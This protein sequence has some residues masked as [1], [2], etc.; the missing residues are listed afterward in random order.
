MPRRH[1]VKD[2]SDEEF[3]FVIHRILEGDTDR[4]L[5]A[6]FEA[7]YPDKKLAKSSLHRW[8]EATGNELAERYRLARFQAKQLLANLQEDGADKHQL[9]MQS[10]EDKLLTAT[11]EVISAD[12]LKLLR[13]RQ[14]EKKRE[15]QE[16]TLDLKE[17]TLDFQKEKADR[18]AGLQADKFN[19]A[20]DAWQF[21][22]R[23]FAQR[24]TSVVD[25]LTDSSEELLQDLESHLENQTA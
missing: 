1:V 24:D 23:W 3:E 19:I 5:S 7:Q 17:R 22:L 15:L 20:A 9:V 13:I 8:R 12:P 6:A 2:L 14:Q 18:E 16:R 4:E 21:I 10:I 25:R 11:R